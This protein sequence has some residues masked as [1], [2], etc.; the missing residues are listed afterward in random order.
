MSI[1][2][3]KLRIR[4]TYSN[5]ECVRRVCVSSLSNMYTVSL[6]SQ[7]LLT[8]GFLSRSVSPV[9]LVSKDVLSFRGA[10]GGW[11]WRLFSLRLEVWFSS[12]DGVKTQN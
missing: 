6:G 3:T 9:S 2:V 5:T 10:Q 8:D 4:V 7:M 11:E 1:N 12:K